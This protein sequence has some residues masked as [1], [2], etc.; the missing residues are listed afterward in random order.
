LNSVLIFNGFSKD[1]IVTFLQIIFYP[2]LAIEFYSYQNHPLFLMDEFS[3]MSL[4]F[5]KKWSNDDVWINLVKIR[6]DNVYVQRV[7]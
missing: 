3:L 4:N 5:N 1:F 7:L 6:G 2:I